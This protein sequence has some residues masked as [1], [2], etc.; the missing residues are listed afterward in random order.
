MAE[1]TTGKKAAIFATCIVDL[2]R[3][4]V[5]FATARLL[6][7]A[8]FDVVVPAGQTCCGQPAYNSG[9][10]DEAAAV[11]RKTIALLEPY[12]HIVVPSASCAG[13]IRNAYPELLEG[14]A[15]WSDRA[16]ELAAKTY[17]LTEFLDSVADWTP[18]PV[19]AGEERAPKEVFYHDSCASLRELDLGDAPRRLLAKC[20]GLSLASDTD[21]ETCCGFG[22][23]FSVKYGE[24]SAHIGGAK[25][26][27]IAK[28]GAGVLAGA[29]LGCLLH[30]EGLMLRRGLNVKVEHIAEVLAGAW[31]ETAAGKS[32]EGA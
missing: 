7:S 17:E 15:D 8:G 31:A 24:L 26:L 11:A 30:L 23:L 22:G 13:M 16:W 6:A 25:A 10:A 1:E 28:S 21:G 12:D 27:R 9:A 14:D 18:P 19:T 4:E 2:M 5:G 3:P 29:D 32:G 20:S